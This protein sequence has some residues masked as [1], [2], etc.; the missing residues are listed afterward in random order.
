MKH[1]LVI[2]F[3]LFATNAYA[4]LEYLYPE[5]SSVNDEWDDGTAASNCH[6]EID[7]DI[8]SLS[9]A[10]Y[11]A[12]TAVTAAAD[13][14]SGNM[15]NTSALGATDTINSVKF[16]ARMREAG[17]PEGLDLT[18]ASGGSTCFTRTGVVTTSFADYT[19]T[20]SDGNCDAAAY[21]KALLDAMTWYIE[22][23]SIGKNDGTS[24]E[25]AYIYIEI[26]Y[27]VA[28]TVINWIITIS[29]N[30]VVDYFDGM[31]EITEIGGMDG[32]ILHNHRAVGTVLTH[33]DR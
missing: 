28:S 12:T 2:V 17:G 8:G 5:D 18:F 15:T 22:S 11:C 16:L 20:D 13:Q 24:W 9:E 21:T 30:S 7:D 1:F 26:D 25:V 4:D 14:Q 27:T 31:P 32:T 23:Q 3:V 6:T 33:L 29:K 10:D 19:T